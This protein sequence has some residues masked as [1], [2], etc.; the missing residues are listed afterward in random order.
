MD[1]GP[2]EFLHALQRVCHGTVDFEIR[3]RAC[4][5]WPGATG[6]DT[7][8]GR[9]ARLPSLALAA[10]ARLDGDAEQPRPELTSAVRVVGGELDQSEGHRC[11]RYSSP[12]RWQ[13]ANREPLLRELVRRKYPRRAQRHGC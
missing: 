11:G 7:E 5:A 3:E 1:H 4:V 8:G 10:A 9:P 12:V 2:P 13:S 6:M